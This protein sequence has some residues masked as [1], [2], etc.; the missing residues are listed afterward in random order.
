MTIAN[1]KIARIMNLFEEDP[2]SVIFGPISSFESWE[3]AI[4]VWPSW[5]DVRAVS[6]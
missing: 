2:I 4:P 5:Y 6:V 1:A 3:L